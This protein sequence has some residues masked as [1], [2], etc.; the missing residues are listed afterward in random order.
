MLNISRNTEYTQK[1][2]V[3]S[4]INIFFL[5]KSFVL[6]TRCYKIELGISYALL[7][8]YSQIFTRCWTEAG[9]HRINRK[10]EDT[11]RGEVEIFFFLRV[12][13]DKEKTDQISCESFVNPYEADGLWGCCFWLT[14]M[15]LG[16]MTKN[17]GWIQKVSYW[18]MN[19]TNI[20]KQDA[21]LSQV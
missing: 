12:W 2:T 3:R 20:L 8:F 4:P 13:N 18:R 5:S 7:K 21:E 1:T 14:Q 15:G 19:H 10:L 17:T 11:G 6:V 9:A 16:T